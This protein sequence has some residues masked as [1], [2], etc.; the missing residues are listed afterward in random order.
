[1]FCCV[2]PNCKSIVYRNAPTCRLLP[3]KQ[4][5]RMN[6][7][8][9]LCFSQT[10]L[11]LSLSPS[12][13][14]CSCLCASLCLSLAKYLM[15]H[16]SDSSDVLSETKQLTVTSHCMFIVFEQTSLLHRPSASSGPS[17][18][19]PVSL[20]LSKTPVSSL[21]GKRNV[22]SAVTAKP[23]PRAVTKAEG[24]AAKSVTKNKKGAPELKKVAKTVETGSSSDVKTSSVR[25]KRT[26]ETSAGP[27][28][29]GNSHSHVAPG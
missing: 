9:K 7:R 29:K 16:W 20:K 10:S 12:T 5:L 25:S 13:K 22:F 8:S 21:P 18:Q 24:K 4:R 11:N 14:R 3:L 6:L 19:K 27:A 15:D 26:P 28:S 1:M 23:G 2:R 17:Q